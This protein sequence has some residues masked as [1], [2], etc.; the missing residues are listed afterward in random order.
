MAAPAFTFLYF[1]EL[2]LF[3]VKLCLKIPGDLF[4]EGLG[5]NLHF[6][7]LRRLRSAILATLR[8]Y[9]EAI[10]LIVVTKNVKTTR[11]WLSGQNLKFSVVR[12]LPICLREERERMG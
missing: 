9:S 1:S 12:P 4:S 11:G 3:I 5:T 10:F 6:F 7:L 2:R 8:W